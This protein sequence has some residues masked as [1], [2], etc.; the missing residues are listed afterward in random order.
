[1]DTAVSPDLIVCVRAPAVMAIDR[2]HELVLDDKEL[3]G[4]AAERA[5]GDPPDEAAGAPSAV[6]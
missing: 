3:R 2:V 6:F 1:M 4:V 5:D